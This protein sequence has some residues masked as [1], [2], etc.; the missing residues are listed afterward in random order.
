MKRLNITYEEFKKQMGAIVRNM[1]FQEDLIGL[2]AEYNRQSCDECEFML[3]MLVDNVVDL[4][5]LATDDK[6]GWIAYWLF[7]LDCGKEYRDGCVT[8][9]D[10]TIIKLETIH[11]L[12][13]LLTE[14]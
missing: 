5:T 10:G 6:D 9:A 2:V 3:P 11:D 14:S 1:H 7:D 8:E 12:W 4:L 13:H